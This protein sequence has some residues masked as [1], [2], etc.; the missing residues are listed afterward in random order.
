[1]LVEVGGQKHGARTKVRSAQGG[2]VKKLAVSAAFVVGLAGAGHAADLPLPTKDVPISAVPGVCTGLTDF[3]LSNCILSWYGVTFFGTVDVGGSYQTHGVPFDPN[4]PTGALYVVG[5]GGNNAPNRTPGLYLGPNAMSQSEVGLKVLEPIASGWS[6]VAQAGVAFDPYSGLLSNAPHAEFNSIHVPENQQSIPY[7][8][9]R[10]GWLGASNYAGI[11]SPVFGTLTFGRQN[12]L[13]NDAVV[14]YDPMGASYA[15]SLIGYSGK[16]AGAG[17]TEDARWT[18]AI[19]YRVNV[20]DVRLSVMGQPVGGTTGGYDSYNPNN[21]AVSGGIGGDIKRGIPGVI[22]LDVIGTYEKDAVNWSTTFPGQTLVGGTP[23]GAN[24]FPV[25]GLKAT[26]SDQTAFMALAKWSFGSWGNTP[27]PIVGK[28]APV[29]SGPSGIPLTLYAGYEWIQFANPSDPQTSSFRDDG[30]LFQPTN[31]LATGLS[32][33]GTTIA[34]NAF[35]SGCKA[36]YTCSNEIFQ[37]IWT[38]AK[39]GITKDLDVIGAYYH[40]IQ[41]QYIAAAN[42]AGAASL[43]Q[44][45]ANLAQCGGTFDMFSAVLDWRF[46]PKWDAYIGTAYSVAYGGV[47]NGDITRNNLSTTGGVRFRF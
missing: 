30:F 41:S 9:S 31:A 14:A 13:E 34:N 12:A 17:D 11:S 42:A 40:Y 29:P 4:H 27:P 19:K 47:A 26:I 5:A 24:P 37:V 6:F 43:C 18:T 32:S 21:G 33:N 44:N 7:D 2:V 36:N 39:Y 38:G 10:W 28:A 20:G 46:L 23:A 16:T 3:L 35:N 1:M 25:G 45:S 22:S 8:S 15:F